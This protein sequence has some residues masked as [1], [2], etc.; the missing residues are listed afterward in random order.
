MRA[1]VSM[2]TRFGPHRLF[3]MNPDV[4]VAVE[5]LDLLYYISG[6]SRKHLGSLLN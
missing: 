4:E 5:D 3:I 2:T 6:K 1:P